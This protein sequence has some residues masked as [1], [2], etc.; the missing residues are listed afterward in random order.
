MQ[1]LSQRRKYSGRTYALV[2]VV[3]V[4]AGLTFLARSQ[5]WVDPGQSGLLRIVV[6]GLLLAALASFV[7]D[8][9]RGLRDGE[10]RR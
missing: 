2:L 10:L 5:G 9:V 8:T 4:V 7:V 3:G 6:G 1:T